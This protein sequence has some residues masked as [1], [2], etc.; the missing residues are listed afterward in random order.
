M[1]SS[2]S[3]S[4]VPTR[5]LVRCICTRKC[6]GPGGGGKLISLR[7]RQRHALREPKELP[8][9]FTALR[10]QP[11]DAPPAAGAAPLGMGLATGKPHMNSAINADLIDRDHAGAGGSLRE[12]EEG[13]LDDVVRCAVVI[14]NNLCLFHI[15]YAWS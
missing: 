15:G 13:F 10:V 2:D 5:P 7:S 4:A 9:S 8:P 6:G 14:S 11:L 1:N 12:D 3:D